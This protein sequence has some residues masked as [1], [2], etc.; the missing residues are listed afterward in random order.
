VL[1]AVV[2]V[3]FWCLLLSAAWKWRRGQRSGA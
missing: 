3:F 2:G 1:G